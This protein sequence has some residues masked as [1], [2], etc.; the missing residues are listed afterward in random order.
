MAGRFEKMYDIALISMFY[1]LI[2]KILNFRS[3]KSP[4]RKMRNHRYRRSGGAGLL[5]NRGHRGQD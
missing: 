1:A 5:R 2:L 3:I 4:T